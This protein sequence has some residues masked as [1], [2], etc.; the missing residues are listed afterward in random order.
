MTL[1]VWINLKKPQ[2]N[3]HEKKINQSITHKKSINQL[4]Q[5]YRRQQQQGILNGLSDELHQD[6]QP[7]TT[8]PVDKQSDKH[9]IIQNFKFNRGSSILFAGANII[10]IYIPILFKSKTSFLFGPKSELTS[11]YLHIGCQGDH[12]HPELPK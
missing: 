10:Q 4:V 9:S 1:W 2:S 8:P 6:Y 7:P 3:K 12:E 11:P 5:I